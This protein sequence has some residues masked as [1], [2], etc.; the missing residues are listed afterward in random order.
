MKKD[1][2][3]SVGPLC[4]PWASFYF[5]AA[6]EAA[7]FG[8]SSAIRL[9]E[10]RFPLGPIPPGRFRAVSQFVDYPR[11]TPLSQVVCNRRFRPLPMSPVWGELA[12]GDRRLLGGQKSRKIFGKWPVGWR[13]DG[14]F[15]RTI[16]GERP[17]AIPPSLP[18]TL[19]EGAFAADEA[20]A[21]PGPWIRWKIPVIESP[22]RR[23]RCNRSRIS[24]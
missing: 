19:S 17:S 6:S 3:T 13:K 24:I 10:S 5:V 21:G 22:G 8:L 23:L 11:R 16:T 14:P 7:E 4:H 18:E 9:T 2:R 15:G 1:T 12:K 20:L